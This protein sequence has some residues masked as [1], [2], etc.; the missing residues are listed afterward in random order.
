MT[1]P[2]KAVTLVIGIAIC[3]AEAPA[4]LF[5]GLLMDC[6]AAEQHHGTRAFSDQVKPSDRQENAAKQ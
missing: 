3:S 2:T 5:G 4:Q 6:Q 1:L